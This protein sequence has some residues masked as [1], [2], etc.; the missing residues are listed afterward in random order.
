VSS[1]DERLAVLYERHAGSVERQVSH[2]AGAPHAVIE[3]ACQTA[4][5]RLCA[6][7]DIGADA[8]GA[9]RWLIVTATREAWR[10]AARRREVPVGGWCAEPAQGELAEPAGTTGDP[11]AVA[12]EHERSAEPRDRLSVLTARERQFLGLQ[13]AGLS[14][15]EIAQTGASMRT[16][17]R[18]ILRARRKLRNAG[19]CLDSKDSGGQLPERD[20]VRAL[21][22][23]VRGCWALE[24]PPRD[25]SGHTS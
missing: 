15:H 10:L 23:L 6:R 11:V 18:Q 22:V 5:T 21:A 4:W 24:S 19:A 16:V 1:R 3:D 14:Y 7:A 2:R 20:G 25:G 17:E 12:I 8:P 13:A 9:V